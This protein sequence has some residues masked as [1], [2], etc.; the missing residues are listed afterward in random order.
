MSRST[1]ARDET[2]RTTS[3][4]AISTGRASSLRPAD[5]S[6]F[7]FIVTNGPCIKACHGHTS[8]RI[9]ACFLAVPL[10]RPWAPWS[11]EARGHSKRRRTARVPEHERAWRS[12]ESEAE[13]YLEAWVQTAS[14]LAMSRFWEGTGRREGWTKRRTRGDGEA[15]TKPRSILA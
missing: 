5:V 15:A 6:S 7:I 8:R 11:H 9:C 12:V 1:D 4:A 3:A 13:T 2:F 10:I 14:V